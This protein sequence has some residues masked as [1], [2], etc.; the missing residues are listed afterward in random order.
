MLLT[1]TGTGTSG[2]LS[3]CQMLS[4]GIRTPPP[5]LTGSG[6]TTNTLRAAMLFKLAQN[7]VC[8]LHFLIF[9][10]VI[11]NSLNTDRIERNLLALGS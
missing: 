10:T 1:T 8:K 3:T 2:C 5:A 6:A 7:F 4:T 11:E 9:I